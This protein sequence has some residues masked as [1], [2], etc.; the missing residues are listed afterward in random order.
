[1]YVKKSVK[2]PLR[3][4]NKWKS[5]KY[6]SKDLTKGLDGNYNILYR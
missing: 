4:L 3:L 1:M 6:G 5:G 2:I